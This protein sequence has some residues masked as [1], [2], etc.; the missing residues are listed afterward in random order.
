[1]GMESEIRKDSVRFLFGWRNEVSLNRDIQFRIFLD[2]NGD[3]N[4]S[5]HEPSFS[6]PFTTSENL[7]EGIPFSLTISEENGEVTVPDN[8][9]KIDSFPSGPGINLTG[10]T[11]K[12]LLIL[13]GIDQ[14]Q[15]TGSYGT[16]SYFYNDGTHNYALISLNSRD[17]LVDRK[18]V[19]SFMTFSYS[20]HIFEGYFNT[21]PGAGVHS[22]NRNQGM[23]VQAQFS[24]VL[25]KALIDENKCVDWEGRTYNLTRLCEYYDLESDDLLLLKGRNR[26]GYPGITA[27]S[28]TWGYLGTSG[29]YNPTKNNSPYTLVFYDHEKKPL[30]KEHKVIIN[31]AITDEPIEGAEVLINDLPM[32]I[33]DKK[34]EIT[35]PTLISGELKGRGG[36]T[37]MTLS[38]ESITFVKSLPP[39]YRSPLLEASEEGRSIY[40]QVVLDQVRYGDAVLLAGEEEKEIDGKMYE[41]HLASFTT[42]EQMEIVKKELDF[43]AEYTSTLYWIGLDIRGD[44]VPVWT[45]TGRPVWDTYHDGFARTKDSKYSAYKITHGYVSATNWSTMTNTDY[46]RAGYVI[47]WDSE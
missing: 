12:A 35:L 29:Y 21:K 39:G 16:I 15:Y 6:I 47:R 42:K 31:H 20:S 9:K 25:D 37:P 38:S 3:H 10:V 18:G 46:R 40:Y 33:T 5:S 2:T 19:N 28:Q 27:Y 17:E 13:D 32:G 30:R 44:N 23:M 1:V 22:F 4:F 36:L 8:T 7:K 41:G 45:D 43:I 24:G 11:A 14:H 26:M 34:G